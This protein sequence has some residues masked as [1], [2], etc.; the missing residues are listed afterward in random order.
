MVSF[1]L[2]PNETIH[3]VQEET[4]HVIQ[5]ML[6][7]HCHPNILRS[8]AMLC[9]FE[10]CTT[11]SAAPST[12][13]ELECCRHRM[14]H[15]LVSTKLHS[16]RLTAK[17]ETRY[18][19]IHNNLFNIH[20]WHSLCQSVLCWA[21]DWL[22]RKGWCWERLRA[23]GEGDDR[24]WGGWMASPMD[25]SLRKLWELVKDREAWSAAV[26]GVAEPDTTEPLH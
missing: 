26:H 9:H 23:G 24:G 25:T 13:Q 16:D 15:R 20:W 11:S 3:F 8:G 22:I 14:Q 7:T 1:S 19:V 17:K 6:S 2:L 12:Q 18:Q 10:R 4:R 21:H 5:Q